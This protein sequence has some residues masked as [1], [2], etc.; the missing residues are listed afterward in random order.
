MGLPTDEHPPTVMEPPDAIDN[1]PMEGSQLSSVLLSQEELPGIIETDNEPPPEGE[2]PTN[3]ES[4]EIEQAEIFLC[5]KCNKDLTVQSNPNREV[6]IKW[7]KINAAK[8]K[9]KKRPNKEAAA[10]SSY[11]IKQPKVSAET[12][13]SSP[14]IQ[15]ASSSV[16]PSTCDQSST[17]S[18]D[19]LLEDIICDETD[20]IEIDSTV[21]GE[22]NNL[23]DRET[24]ETGKRLAENSAFDDQSIIMVDDEISGSSN[25]LYCTGVVPENMRNEIFYLFPFQLLPELED[26][27]FSGDAI[28]HVDCM[29]MNYQLSAVSKYCKHFVLQT[30]ST[31]AGKKRGGQI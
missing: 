23:N 13:S 11:F 6:H 8:K 19:D 1:V 5:P 14:L 28:H 16:S 21:V 18:H 31:E 27:V 17:E 3:D 15:T 12:P 25:M 20:N 4:N 22:N 24:S 9:V 30:S 2:I 10:F 26:I 7:C 29:K